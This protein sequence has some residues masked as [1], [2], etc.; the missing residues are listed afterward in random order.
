[1]R[2]EPLPGARFGALRQAVFRRAG[3]LDLQCLQVLHRLAPHLVQQRCRGERSALNFQSKVG[4]FI[5]RVPQP[6][7]LIAQRFQRQDPVARGSQDGGRGRRDGKFR[8]RCQPPLGD[9]CRA[10]V[11]RNLHADRLPL[12][13]NRRLNERPRQSRQETDR[14]SAKPDLPA[15]S[16]RSAPRR[17]RSGV[18][19]IDRA[20][21]ETS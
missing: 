8:T 4:Q 16:A 3:N 5:G 10:L 13:R 1:M 12:N 9:Q 21:R 19:A 6:A 20:V 15:G 11:R 18:P 7:E 17:C 14:A 2:F